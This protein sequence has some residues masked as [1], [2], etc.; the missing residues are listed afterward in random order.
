MP[1]ACRA[2]WIVW[3]TVAGTWLSARTRGGS[4][5]GTVWFA[6]RQATAIH[7]STCL[8]QFLRLPFSFSVCMQAAVPVQVTATMP[9]HGVDASCARKREHAQRQHENAIE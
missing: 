9:A 3:A 8:A 5:K 2:F 7:G 1:F 6:R 4:E